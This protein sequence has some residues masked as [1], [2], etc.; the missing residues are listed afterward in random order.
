MLIVTIKSSQNIFRYLFRSVEAFN[1][2]LY[3]R[4]FEKI[5]R[6]LFLYLGMNTLFGEEISFLTTS[7]SDPRVLY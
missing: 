5:L 3:P 7:K 1:T 6:S 4:V 2:N